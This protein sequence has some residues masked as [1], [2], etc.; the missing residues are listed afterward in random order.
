MRSI[1]PYQ[2]PTDDTTYPKPEGDRGNFEI[3]FVKDEIERYE[4]LPKYSEIDEKERI[5]EE[6]TKL[7]SEI[8]ELSE[9][10]NELSDDEFDRRCDEID[11]RMKSVVAPIHREP[12]SKVKVANGSYYWIANE[13]TARSKGKEFI[14]H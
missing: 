13:D 1:K 11:H 9:L 3:L 6:S 14:R 5:L 7:M 4:M 10:T 2:L 12:P 8:E